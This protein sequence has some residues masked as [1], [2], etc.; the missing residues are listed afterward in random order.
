MA[1][2]TLTYDKTKNIGVLTINRPKALNAIN[3]QMLMDLDAQLD[4]VDSDRSLRVL[5]ITGGGE[6]A[7]V[8]GADI[9]EMN[10]MNIEQAKEFAKRGQGVMRRLEIFKVPVIAAVNG[11]ALGGGTELACACDFII[12]SEKAKFGQPEVLLGLMP[13][14]GGTQRLARSIGLARA[15]QLIYTGEQIDAKLAYEWGLVNKVVAPDKLMPEVMKIAEAIVKAAPLGI[16][17]SKESINDGYDVGIDKGLGFELD[18]F[19]DLFETDDVKE[20][21]KAFLEKREA[22]FNGE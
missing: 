8:A 7:F 10:K 9:S 22:H 4:E 5:I 19:C 18:L 11:F 1:F 16:A 2:E 3:V 6:K 13:G 21:T 12:A 14:F 20:G 17:G 15:R